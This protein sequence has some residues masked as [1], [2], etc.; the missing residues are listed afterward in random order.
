MRDTGGARHERIGRR[1]DGSPPAPGAN[2]GGSKRILGKDPKK[3]QD[4]GG[5]AQSKLLLLLPYHVPRLLDFFWVK[6][7][8]SRI[9]PP[10]WNN[11]VPWGTGTF[12]R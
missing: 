9:F 4:P 1:S 8:K 5:G 11:A 6:S 2:R 12:S 10:A 7:L 3:N